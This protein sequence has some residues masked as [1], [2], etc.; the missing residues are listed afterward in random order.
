MDSRCIFGGVIVAACMTRS[1]RHLHS[2][3]VYG[4]LFK[5]RRRREGRTIM[6]IA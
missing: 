1:Y 5:S 3:G 4:V 2:D 6:S